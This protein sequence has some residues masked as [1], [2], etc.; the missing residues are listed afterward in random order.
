[1]RVRISG[2]G[3]I[4]EAFFLYGYNALFK[5]QICC[6]KS[7]ELMNLKWR[8]QAIKRYYLRIKAIRMLVSKRD[9]YLSCV[10]RHKRE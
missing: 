1:M 5:R 8:T 2:F 7:R 6:N 3:V 10:K 4:I 9:M